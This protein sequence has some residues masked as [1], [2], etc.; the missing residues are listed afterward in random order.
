[1]CFCC[2]YSAAT[3]WFSISQKHMGMCPP[4]NQ[5]ERA[6]PGL[7]L[8]CSTQ[9][10]F[11][12]W[13]RLTFHGELLQGT[14]WKGK[15]YLANTPVI[16]MLSPGKER[17]QKRPSDS[18]APKLQRKLLPNDGQEGSFLSFFPFGVKCTSSSTWNLTHKLHRLLVFRNPYP[19]PKNWSDG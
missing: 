15:A 5:Q 11:R 4:A 12:R 6:A 7:L 16:S 9:S 19:N 8:P 10:D 13:Q 18:M 2:D 3:G 14:C 17:G 1:M